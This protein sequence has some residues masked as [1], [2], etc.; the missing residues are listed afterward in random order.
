MAWLGL[1]CK[2]SVQKWSLVAIDISKSI[3]LKKVRVYIYIFNEDF[4]GS[5]SDGTYVYLTHLIQNQHSF[6]K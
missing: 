2:I 6:L 1:R 4:P 3:A 5:L